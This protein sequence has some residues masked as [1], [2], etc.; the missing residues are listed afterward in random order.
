MNNCAVKFQS[1]LRQL[2]NLKFIEI[3]YFA[4]RWKW[5]GAPMPVFD[6]AKELQNEL[7]TLGGKPTLPLH[8]RK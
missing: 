6:R 1:S 3:L 4:S 5:S 7:V 8:F 2:E